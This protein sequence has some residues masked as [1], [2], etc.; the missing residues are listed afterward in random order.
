[1]PKQRVHFVGIGGTGT[2][3]LARMLLREGCAV[4]GSDERETSAL[5]Q[6]ARQGA[7]VYLGHAEEHVDGREDVVVRSAAIRDDN[8]EITAA[9]RLGV[10]VIK[11]AQ[12]LGRMMSRKVGI[13]VA[14][15]H[16]KTTTTAM[17]AYILKRAGLDPSFIVGGWVRK[18]RGSSGAGSGRYFVA[19]ACEYDRS[20]LNMKPHI[21]V[22]TNIE[23][24]HLDYY[25]DLDEIVGAFREFAAA[26]AKDGLLVVSGQDRNV[27]R[28]IEGLE[29]PIETC[30]VS[31]DSDWRADCVT[32]TTRRNV[33]D[34]AWR[35]KRQGRVS[36]RIPGTHNVRNAL[37]AIAVASRL[38]VPFE[39]IKKA[40]ADFNGADRRFQIVGSVDGITILDDYAHHPTEIQVTLKAARQYFEPKRMVCVFQPHQYSRTRCLLKDFAR[41]FGQADCV[42]VP[43]I[44]FVRDSIE[45]KQKVSAG[46]LVAEIVN[47]G[48]DA[49]HIPTLE[50]IRDYLLGEITSGD[51][52]ITM[53]AGNVNE[54]AYDVFERVNGNHS[55]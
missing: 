39:C 7:R 4:S 53:G 21:G 48:G 23:E 6:L 10:P 44:Y 19:E 16:G 51:L 34:V 18:L 14:G 41:S 29:C 24:D 35:G 2:C 32:T 45:E 37:A 54:V 12:M 50:G 30:A 43:D 26:V 38:G 47:L 11:Y 31:Q 15:T 17:V 55:P 36:L 3:G 28:A 9:G 27:A 52:V 20:F 33:F 40:L 25:K 8:P 22:I 5:S 1:V 46:H 42:V 13:A 49:R